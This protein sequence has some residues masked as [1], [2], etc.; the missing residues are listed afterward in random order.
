MSWIAL[1]WI[2]RCAP[3]VGLEQTPRI[4]DHHAVM[5]ETGRT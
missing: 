5:M 4:P 2:A 1:S 3:V